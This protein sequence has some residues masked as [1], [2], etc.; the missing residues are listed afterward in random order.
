IKIYSQLNE[1]LG[2]AMANSHL[3]LFHHALGDYENAI[4]CNN[5]AIQE[6]EAVGDKYLFGLSY[7]NLGLVHLDRCEFDKAKDCFENHLHSSKEI[8][9]E[10][11]MTISSGNLGTVFHA[12]GNFDKAITF[13]SQHRQLSKKL[14]YKKGEALTCGH[15]GRIYLEQ[16]RYKKAIKELEKNIAISSEISDKLGEGSAYS[17]LGGIYLRLDNL[18]KAN[19]YLSKAKIVLESIGSRRNLIELYNRFCEL[20]LKQKEELV[21]ARKYVKKASQLSKE[22]KNQAGMATSLLNCARIASHEKKKNA[23]EQYEKSI[24]IF[25]KLGMK[26]KLADSWMEYG[27]FLKE[28]G[29]EEYKSFIRKAKKAYKEMGVPDTAAKSLV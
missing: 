27:I 23:N 6:G 20:S 5:K 17:E 9:D 29:K 4:K 15:F 24:K 14:G 13:Y 22:L 26:K 28:E 11:G 12:L 21:I 10:W 3:G 2:I 18:E 8:G 7:G 1:R 25:E 16:E 19:K